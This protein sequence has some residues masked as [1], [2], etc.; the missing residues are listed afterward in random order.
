MP[1]RHIL[2][3]VIC[4]V[5]FM[6]CIVCGSYISS[7]LLAT[8]IIFL[9]PISPLAKYFSERGKNK[10]RALLAFL[11]FFAG[12]MLSPTAAEDTTTQI[13]TVPNSAVE[14]AVTPEPT[15]VPT[16]TATPSPS[17]T[18]T[19][20][21]TPTPEPTA[22]PEPTPEPTPVP[23]ET[24]APTPVPTPEPTP[25]PTQA[26]AQIPAQQNT[27]GDMVYIASSGKGN[28]YHSSPGC[29]SLSKGATAVTLEYALSIG[30]TPCGIC[31]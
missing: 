11:A 2:L 10:T 3:W 22:T 23:T 28:R 9:L 29:R 13:E 30:R 4:F 26:P 27:Q 1:K 12:V 19:A 7:L 6:F 18:P 31:Y 17:P 25:V 15:A 14:I 24:P 8:S 16:P 21:P 5:L 20:T